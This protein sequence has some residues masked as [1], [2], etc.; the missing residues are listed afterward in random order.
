VS[1]TRTTIEKGIMA[2]EDTVEGIVTG[3]AVEAKYADELKAFREQHKRIR[4]WEIEGH[5]LF[6][7]RRPK[8]TDLQVY[9]KQ[10]D[11]EGFDRTV[12][13]ENYVQSVT[14][15]PATPEAVRAVFEDWSLFS[16][17]AYQATEALG[18]GVVNELKKA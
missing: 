3:E 16:A 8:R 9:R 14:V 4:F 1:T 18:G 10:L 2:D 6:V 12:A 7:I 11:T 13:I 17:V 5:G 15:A